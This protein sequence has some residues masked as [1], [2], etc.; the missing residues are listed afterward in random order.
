[1]SGEHDL[2][3]PGI[4]RPGGIWTIIGSDTGEFAVALSKLVGP[5][6]EIYVVEKSERALEKVRRDLARRAPAI[7][8]HC[9][10]AD[11]MQPVDLPPLDGMVVVN[12]LHQ[13]KL[14]RQ[15]GV[16]RHLREFLKPH[17]GRL[18]LVD[19]EV[20]KGSL[21]VRYPVNYE[22]FEYLAGVAG[23]VEMRR[24]AALPVGL[25]REIYAALAVRGE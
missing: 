16:L 14:E 17:G 21:R 22:S 9:V 11:Y 18:I 10:R 5:D 3:A 24:I 7:H 25:S 4:L 19:H 2:L 23:F 8:I 13:V 6:A 1:M 15:Q 12:V 20:R